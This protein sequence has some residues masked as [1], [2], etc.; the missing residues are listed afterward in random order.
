MFRKLRTYLLTI[1]FLRKNLYNGL[2]KGAVKMKI[3]ISVMFNENEGS[4]A[5]QGNNI[6]HETINLLKADDGKHYIYIA[7]SGNVHKSNQDI[8]YLLL[9]RAFSKG[10]VQVVSL[11]ENPTYISKDDDEVKKATKLYGGKS[12]AE[13]YK[14]NTGEH[15]DKDRCI[16]FQ[17]QNGIWMPKNLILISSLTQKIFFSKDTVVKYVKARVRNQSMR[18]YLSDKN[19]DDDSN[20]YK[21]IKELIDDA[22][23]ENSTLWEPTV[24]KTVAETK[25]PNIEPTFM[26]IIGKADNEL[27]F[28]NMFAYFFSKYP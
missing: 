22:L 28:S 9:V 4:Y 21:T 17:A 13:L 3:L 26:D 19:T 20:D 11:I 24:Y 8:T 2:K 18:L 15:P 7:P 25:T 6:V 14:Q 16:T 12:L 5:L 23:A 10:T 27:A 1:D